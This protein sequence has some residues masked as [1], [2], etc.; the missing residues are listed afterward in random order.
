MLRIFC[1]CY[2]IRSLFKNNNIL[3]TREFFIGL[4]IIVNNSYFVSNLQLIWVVTFLSVV[5]LHVD[6]GILLGILFS[7]FT[8]VIRTQR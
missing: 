7:F 6:Y 1:Y 8:V 5:V 4:Y 2:A 3:E